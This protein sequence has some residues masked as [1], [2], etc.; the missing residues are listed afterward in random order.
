MGCLKNYSDENLYKEI[1]PKSKIIYFDINVDLLYNLL[2]E[3][4]R[5]FLNEDL[6]SKNYAQ[7][8]P[9]RITYY[10]MNISNDFGFAFKKGENPLLEEFNEILKIKTLKIYMKNGRN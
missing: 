5:D 6:A 3:N 9:D 1:F 4:Y 7:K 10:D 8:F 2:S